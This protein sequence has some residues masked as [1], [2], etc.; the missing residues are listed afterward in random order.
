MKRT[1]RARALLWS[2]R[3]FGALLVAAAA[4][5]VYA[6]R[7]WDAPLDAPRPSIHADRS[8][9]AIARGAAIFHSTCEVCHRAAGND[10]ASGAP[11]TDAPAFLGTFYAANLTSDRES[12]IGAVAD[13]D[14]ARMIRYGVRRTGYRGLMPTYGMGDEDVAAVLG[15]MRSDDPMF[16]PDP[17][18]S[19]PSEVT[20]VGK[21]LLVAMGASTLP[22][23]PA[24]GLPVPEKANTVAYGRYLAHDVFDCVGCHT[25]GFSAS[26]A[27]GPDA[28]SGGFVFRD[29]LGR[30]VPSR[31]LTPD[32]TGLAH[33][34][35]EDLARALRRGQR[36]DGTVLSA[37]MPMFRGLEDV[38]IDALYTY[39]RSLPPRR[40]EGEGRTPP[41][42]SVA[43]GNAVAKSAAPAERFQS[44]GCVGCH[45]SGA[46]H[47]R[48]LEKAADKPAEDLARWIRNP[49]RY[50]P[51]TPMPTYEDLLDEQAALELAIW[52]KSGGPAK[53][54]AR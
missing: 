54:A 43:R 42:P 1:K 6:V 16:R 21:A 49:E 39:L 41:A 27:S 44:L 53:L 33:Y 52:V 25:P 11:V 34:T 50:V 9:A 22:D 18:K 30:P 28:F 46:Q 24:R 14:V 51:G 48:A 19:P 4:F 20:V 7:K 35:R 32:A 45:G 38:E 8:P 2:A 17:Q 36:P 26:K 15:F 40:N 29:P 12:G 37:P 47:A 23:R 13:G 3:I 31:N 10:R 5:V